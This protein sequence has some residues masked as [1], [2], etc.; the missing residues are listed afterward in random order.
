M[1]SRPPSAIRHPPFRRAFTFVELLVV[2]TIIGILIALLLPAV[3]AA[4]EAARRMQCA[5]NLKQLGVAMANYESAKGCFPPGVIWAKN[6][7]ATCLNAL[8]NCGGPRVN[9]HV[10]LFPYAEQSDAYDTIDF[11][12]GIVFLQNTPATNASLL[13]LL[14]PS[15]GLG[16]TSMTQSG[17]NI[18]MGALQLFWRLQR[19]DDGRRVHDRPGEACHVWREYGDPRPTLAMA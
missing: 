2:I 9:F 7:N 11:S 14:C 8:N 19:D 6:S 16:G 12:G 3:Q 13:Y 18:P 10:Q 1:C 17:Y 5:N 4:R 15:D